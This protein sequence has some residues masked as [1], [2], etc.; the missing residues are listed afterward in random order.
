MN[1][2]YL[3]F[4][5]V[6]KLQNSLIRTLDY[7]N[8]NDKL[9]LIIEKMQSYIKAKGN[10]QIGPLIQ[11][12]CTSINEEGKLNIEIK[13]LLQCKNFIHNLEK[14]YT[15]ESLIRVPNCMYCRYTGPEDKLSFAYD[16]IQLEAFENDISLKNENYT[17]FVDRDDENE[18]IIADVFV[19]RTDL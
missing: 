9:E 15:M 14:G 4:Q 5:K 17:I 10:I 7:A 19:E 1:K 8:E 2:L 16:K 13:L 6:L 3:N 12:T 11:Y 18:R